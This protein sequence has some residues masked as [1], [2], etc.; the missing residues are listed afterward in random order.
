MVNEKAK[1]TICPLSPHSTAHK[2][3]KNTIKKKK[4]KE[5]L[6]Q[7]F[8][9]GLEVQAYTLSIRKAKAEGLQIW[10]QPKQTISKQKQNNTSQD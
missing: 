6:K 9:L 10:D 1:P 3:H 7:I 2:H 5:T 4:T 8:S